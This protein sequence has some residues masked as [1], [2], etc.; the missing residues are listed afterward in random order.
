M[1]V[2]LRGRL[3]GVAEIS[4]SQSRQTTV[5]NFARGAHAFS[6]VAFRDAVDEAGVEVLT[7]HIEACGVIE[8]NDS[9]RW[10]VAGKNRFLLVEGEPAP[11]GRTLCVSGRLDDRSRPLRLTIAGLKP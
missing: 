6:P 3:E 8:Q 7:F 10:L 4:I 1:E 11:A 5:V 9:Q 2:A